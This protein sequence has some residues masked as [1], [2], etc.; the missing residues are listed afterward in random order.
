MLAIAADAPA[1]MPHHGLFG[2]VILAAVGVVAASLPLGG[3]L[4]PDEESE[5]EPQGWPLSQPAS[6]ELAA[7]ARRAL[8]V[9]GAPASERRTGW[10]TE[11]DSIDA[12]RTVQ[13]LDQVLADQHPTG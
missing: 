11:S 13:W 6:D 3:N 1:S 12:G 2:A 9:V 4:L 10:V 8:A 7:L 5:Y